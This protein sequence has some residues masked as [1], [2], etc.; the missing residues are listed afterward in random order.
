MKLR[1]IN[2]PD[3]SGHEITMRRSLVIILLA[4]LF[5]TSFP[6]KAT[7]IVPEDTLC[8][9]GGEAIQTYTVLSVYL[10]DDVDMDFKRYGPAM[11]L[12]TSY[13][14]C[15]S[16]GFVVFKKEFTS[17]E[18]ERLS[19]YMRSQEFR[20]ARNEVVN[21]RAFL[22]KKYLGGYSKAELGETLLRATWQANGF[23][24]Y[25]KYAQEAWNYFVEESE[26]LRGQSTDDAFY[27][28]H[29]RGELSR[30]LMKYWDAYLTFSF[31]ISRPGIKESGYHDLA[32]HQ[33]WATLL[34]WFG[35]LPAVEKDF[36]W[37]IEKRIFQ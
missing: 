34:F 18:L 28:M 31:Q 1:T 22:L 13:P 17:I 12:V 37:A 29:I 25:R 8:P 36:L 2:Q 24:Q 32:R 14:E 26:R 23:W 11:D 3:E 10:D 15:P 16:N 21:Y 9:V 20:S 30:R 27:A 5:I 6:A 4:L 7:V 19:V 35:K 33:R